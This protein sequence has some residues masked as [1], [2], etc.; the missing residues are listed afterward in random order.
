MRRR[1]S[2]RRRGSN[3]CKALALHAAGVGNGAGDA[4]P[5]ARLEA[6]AVVF[7]RRLE[8]DAVLGDALPLDVQ[9]APG[10]GRLG[11]CC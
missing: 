6:P 3:V 9:L 8:R 7:E 2:H 1:R 5:Q 4:G 11:L 10:D